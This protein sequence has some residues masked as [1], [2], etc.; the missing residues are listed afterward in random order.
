MKRILTCTVLLILTLQLFAT[1]LNGII[2]DEKTQKPL[3]GVQIR[4]MK[5]DLVSAQAVTYADGT[6]SI[7]L[8]ENSDYKIY[9]SKDGYEEERMNLSTIF[10]A[11]IREFPLLDLSLSPVGA[12]KESNLSQSSMTLKSKSINETP[13]I[14][15][16][17]K[18]FN[19]ENGLLA[20]FDVWLK[21]N[22]TGELKMTSSDQSGNYIFSLLPNVNYE[23]KLNDQNDYQFNSFFVSTIGLNRSLNIIRNVEGVYTGKVKEPDPV[24]ETKTVVSDQAPIAPAPVPTVEKRKKDKEA[25]LMEEMNRKY[26]EV[27]N[28]E[29]E[30]RSK[31]ERKM[32]ARNVVVRIT[33]VERNK[34]KEM[35]EHAKPP[36]DEVFD[37]TYV[38]KEEKPVSEE[39]KKVEEV[40]EKMEEKKEVAPVAVDKPLVVNKAEPAVEVKPVPEPDKKLDKRPAMVQPKVSQTP[41]PDPVA[42]V[43]KPEELKPEKAEAAV[44]PAE[45]AVLDKKAKQEAENRRIDSMIGTGPRFMHTE[46]TS[47]D[48]KRTG[49]ND[50]DKSKLNPAEAYDALTQ[51]A[52]PIP[53][54]DKIKKFLPVKEDESRT[55]VI[56]NKIYFG[57]GKLF[58]D[59]E[60]KEFLAGIATRMR[61]NPELSL[62]VIVHCDANMEASIMDYVCKS[63]SRKVLDELMA[64]GVTFSKVVIRIAGT[65]QSVNDCKKGMDNCTEL[66][67]QLNRRI[68]FQFQ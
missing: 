68:E 6:F 26:Q 4:V 28:A 41:K 66:D 60:A 65:S 18:V 33:D 2:R 46:L 3:S 57:P 11:A 53:S 34:K 51:G 36:A 32:V 20:G 10:R 45:T 54:A 29:K 56:D 16:E 13:A 50:S 22:L 37:D 48:K 15:L 64:K 30:R 21:N 12:E 8:S 27:R 58:L 67:H 43:E 55:P 38:K 39:V 61:N 5:G 44:K 14:T 52:T 63:R 1:K 31:S 17:G 7:D 24:L 62:D 19:R 23:L 40:A 59:E 42:K 9:I 35:A 25:E 47:E 49:I